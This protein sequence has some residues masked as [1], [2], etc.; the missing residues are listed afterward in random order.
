MAADDD[1]FERLVGGL[2]KPSKMPGF[3]YGLPALYSCNIGARLAKIAN[4]VCST[5]YACKGH[6][7]ISTV[8]NAQ[9]RRYMLLFNPLW[10]YAMVRTI[11]RRRC[12]FFRWHDSGDLI[13]MQHLENIIE[14]A[15]QLPNYKFWLPTREYHL[16]FTC[17]T[18][19]PPN[20]IVRL[21]GA[22]I[23]GPPPQTKLCTSTVHKANLPIG[24]ECPAPTQDGKCR[25]CRAC[26]DPN[27]KNVSYREH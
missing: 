22:M 5:C 19:F 3:G 6:Y 10:V 7:S 1:Y 14:V 26:W 9:R 18:P 15:N 11:K 2:S 13:S 16:V 20:L 12:K 27:I 23:D 4:S 24:H 17:Q 25:D 8:K 21:S